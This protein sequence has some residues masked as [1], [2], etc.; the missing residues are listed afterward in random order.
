MRAVD[1]IGTFAFHSQRGGGADTPS[2]LVSLVRG[3]FRAAA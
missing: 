2:P 1:E 3:A